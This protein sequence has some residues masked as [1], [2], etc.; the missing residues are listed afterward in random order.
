MNA[1]RRWLNGLDE[2]D[3]MEIVALPLAVALC[4]WTPFWPWWWVG[5]PLGML[6]CAIGAIVVMAD[7]RRWV[8]RLMCRIGR[9]RWHD[10]WHRIE[11]P[12]E[13][14]LRVCGRAECY[15]I[16]TRQVQ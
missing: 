14:D 6:A 1:A 12:A 5:P 13:F 7:D 15:E 2:I 16:Q 9:H 4:L 8:G 10:D 3:R 11:Y